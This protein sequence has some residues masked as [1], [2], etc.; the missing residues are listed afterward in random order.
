L[1]ALLPIFPGQR[2]LWSQP[3]P[4]PV[5]LDLPGWKS[6]IIEPDETFPNQRSV[7]FEKAGARIELMRYWDQPRSPGYPMAAESEREI[8]I[9]GQ[10]TKLITTSMFE[11]V[12]QRVHVFWLTGAG[13]DVTY[14]VRVVV[15]RERDVD[16]ALAAVR[17]AW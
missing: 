8:V 16:E 15:R 17:R 5:V 1:S 4:E 7:T 2:E 11:G 10:S 6:S 3:R 13:H 9:A 12:A 14:G